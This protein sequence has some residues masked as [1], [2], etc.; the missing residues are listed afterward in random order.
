MAKLGDY[1]YSRDDMKNDDV[2]I[3]EIEG[4]TVDGSVEDID[5]CMVESNRNYEG[6]IQY[7]GFDM[8]HLNQKLIALISLLKDILVCVF[9]IYL[10]HLV[11]F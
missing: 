7:M 1:N 11:L 9:W 2:D 10:M 4:F 3:I 6:R 5:M 8:M